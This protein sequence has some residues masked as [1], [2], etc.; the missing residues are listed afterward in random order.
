MVHVVGLPD[1]FMFAHRANGLPLYAT[2][3]FTSMSFDLGS[4][5]RAY[6]V[7]GVWAWA[8]LGMG[9]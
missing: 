1:E 2:F 7:P 4:G 3:L 9:L 5:Y 6:G 8:T